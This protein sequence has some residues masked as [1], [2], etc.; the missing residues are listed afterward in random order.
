MYHNRRASLHSACAVAI[1]SAIAPVAHAT[2]LLIPAY[3]Y[4]AGPGDD[5]SRMATAAK[6]VSL[7]AIMNPGNGPGTTTDPNYTPVIANMHAAGGRVI[8][9]LYT[10]DGSRPL[11]SVETDVD[12][13]VSLYNIDGIFVDEMAN[14]NDPAHLTYYSQ[15]YSYI[16]SK[17]KDL[18]VVGNPGTSTLEQYVST[19]TVDTV[20][21]FED[22]AGYS[23]ATPPSWTTKYQ[24]SRFAN[25]PYQVSSSST[26]TSYLTLAQQR[27]VGNIYVTDDGADGN[28]WDRLPTYWNNEVSAIEAITPIWNVTGSG[29]WNLASHWTSGVIPNGV[30]VTAQLT[31]TPAANL[32][33]FTN[34]A[35]TVG[36]LL[37]NNSAGYVVAGA[38]SLTMDVS[39]G[40]A[41]IDVRRGQQ[42]INLPMTIKDNTSVL[43][44]SGAGLTISDP[45]TL[46]GGVTLSKNGTGTL[47]I[48]STIHA[49]APATIKINNGVANIIAANSDPNVSINVD[50]ATVN[51][52]ADQTLGDVTLDLGGNVVNLDPDAHLT[53]RSLHVSGGG[54]ANVIDA[55]LGTIT[56]QDALQIDDG[57][58]LIK[59]GAAM[60]HVGTLAINGSGQFD[61]AGGAM[62]V[63]QNGVGDVD[64]V[65]KLLLRGAL[66]NSTLTDHGALGYAPS[67][68]ATLVQS[69]LAGDSNLDGSVNASDFVSMASHFGQSG[70]WIDGDFNYDGIV[71]AMDF[72][73][74]ASSYGS[75]FAPTSAIGSVV[76]EPISFGLPLALLACSRRRTPLRR[77]SSNRS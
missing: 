50:P 7:T 29:D 8:G 22:S 16:K 71:N 52:T 27:N 48:S 64:S 13:W 51:I 45:L 56:V 38:G 34:K 60:L 43:I 39:T 68:D 62:L 23:T 67:G 6:T 53:A 40:S 70:E 77:R 15:L 5:W 65:R 14:D 74:L 61:L 30:D 36:S 55:P 11:A 35:I 44:A 63:D 18:S 20:T 3:F 42:N 37:F 26:M 58:R 19:P 66:T 49:S 76:P 28:P 10:S 73:L 46:S 24:S 72:N 12:R 4:P 75:S 47:T 9:Y 57:S 32:T 33:V 17:G 25:L 59:R 1:A 41:L 54:D 2:N 69:T 31:G 21:T